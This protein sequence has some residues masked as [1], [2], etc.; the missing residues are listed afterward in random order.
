MGFVS[1]HILQLLI[2]P[3]KIP[4][5]KKLSTCSMPDDVLCVLNLYYL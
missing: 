5:N 4:V 3:I 2:I 1:A